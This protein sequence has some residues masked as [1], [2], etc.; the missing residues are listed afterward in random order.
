MSDSSHVTIKLPKDLVVEMDKLKGQHGFRSRGEIAKEA[1]RRLINYYEE[2]GPTL[3]RFE[4]INFDE[5]GV[6][7]LDRALHRV[8]DVY[9]TPE[10]IKCGLCRESECDHVKFALSQTDIQNV[11]LKRKEEG[12]KLP[13]V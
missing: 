6:K 9:I 11:I 13:D 12:W 4:Q 3:P 10:E 5:N 7:I 1:V 2:K 8:A